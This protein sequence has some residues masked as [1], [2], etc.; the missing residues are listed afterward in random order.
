[1]QLLT[2]EELATAL[3]VPLSW[4]YEQSRL[5]K[6]PTIRIG[7]YIRFDLDTVLLKLKGG[8]DGKDQA[9]SRSSSG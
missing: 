5:G 7:K 8:S 9:S 3:K 2:P 4:I 6:L 1:M